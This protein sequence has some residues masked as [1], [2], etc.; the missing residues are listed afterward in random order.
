MSISLSQFE[1]IVR[2]P[3]E[4]RKE[5]KKL[6]GSH[7]SLLAPYA[8]EIA[9]YVDFT[10]EGARLAA[11][12]ALERSWGEYVSEDL[13]VEVLNHSPKHVYWLDRY[14]KR[15]E[16]CE[17][18]TKTLTGAGVAVAVSLT[19]GPE[20]NGLVQRYFNGF[21]SP[22]D[23]AEA[24]MDL[25]SRHGKLAH[26][27][28]VL[29]KSLAK[30]PK[31]WWP[32]VA[33]ELCS[34]SSPP[35]GSAIRVITSHMGW[36]KLA[37]FYRAMDKSFD[38][39]AM[40]RCGLPR[41]VYAEPD[42]A[43]RVRKRVGMLQKEGSSPNSF[44]LVFNRDV[45]LSAKLEVLERLDEVKVDLDNAVNGH[46]AGLLRYWCPRP[47]TLDLKDT[48]LTDNQTESLFTL[49]YV[50]GAFKLRNAIQVKEYE[51][52]HSKKD[53]WRHP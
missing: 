19:R 33:D 42:R 7:P 20:T 3:G 22:H 53:L 50:F 28:G 30:V 46:R 6:M 49:T 47:Y 11:A 51:L 45:D 9:P 5:L 13:A 27:G 44:A 40:R 34:A 17:N 36:K 16:I 21:V 8:N 29:G 35:K 48:I 25:S 4:H 15:S 43:F 38:E 52:T 1:C 37:C 24:L 31:D 18:P 41:E 10:P 26:L 2:F 23:V 39:E 14:W 12:Y 32:E